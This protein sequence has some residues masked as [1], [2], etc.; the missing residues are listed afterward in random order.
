MRRAIDKRKFVAGQQL[1][2]LIAMCLFVLGISG[3]EVEGVGILE[4]FLNKREKNIFRLWQY[5][6][7]TSRF[8]GSSA[9]FD[10]QY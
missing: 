8:R 7:N 3:M 5:M 10:S 6:N 4:K 9:I 1:I 2:N